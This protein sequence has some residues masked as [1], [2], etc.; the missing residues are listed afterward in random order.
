SAVLVLAPLARQLQ[1]L[2]LPPRRLGKF[3]LLRVCRRQRVEIRRLLPLAPF[4]SLQGMFDRLGGV[5]QVVFRGGGQQPGDG[6]VR[7]RVVGAA[8]EGGTVVGQRSCPV[9]GQAARHAAVVIG[10]RF[11]GLQSDRLAE[12]RDGLR[13]AF[14]PAADEA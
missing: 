3:P 13:E 11:V 4:A 14:H 12:V 10:Q 8:G 6:I 2:F 7:R 1:R 5:A 9:A